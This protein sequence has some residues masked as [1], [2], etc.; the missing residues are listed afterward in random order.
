MGILKSFKRS[1]RIY[2][3]GVL[4]ALTLKLIFATVRWSR[5]DS[6][7]PFVYRDGRQRIFAFWHGRV[8]MMPCLYVSAHR[9]Q[10]PKTKGVY[11][12][13]SNHSDGR[14]ISFGVKLMGLLT[15]NG[16][17][18]RNAASGLH[19]LIKRI[20]DGYDVAI[21]CDGPKGPARVM[22]PGGIMLGKETG[23][24]V[25]PVACS[26]NRYWTVNSWDK[27]M[28]PKPFAKAVCIVGEPVVVPRETSNE[29]VHR[30]CEE[31]QARIN[32]VTDEADSY[33]YS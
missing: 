21:T 14:I 10:S 1:L 18:S 28:I 20:Q 22:K 11:T 32:K 5:N 17:S 23:V 13:I 3:L 30:L 25:F 26:A 31:F 8:L 4:G 2:F 15:V 29:D 27:M 16:S 33:D 6:I 19:G 7:L 12:L 24:P 9:N